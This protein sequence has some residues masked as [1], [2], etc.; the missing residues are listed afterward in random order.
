M[1][2]LE[3]GDEG[4]STQKKVEEGKKDQ[5]LGGDADFHWR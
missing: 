1:E 2:P 3:E 5:V 4:E